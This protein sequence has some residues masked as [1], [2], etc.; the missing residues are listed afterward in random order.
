M[1]TDES[2]NIAMQILKRKFPETKGLD[3]TALGK[4]HQLS[5]VRNKFVQVLH[6]G[7]CHWVCV[8]N[9]IGNKKCD[10]S[11][12]HFYDSLN[13]TGAIKKFIEIQICSFLFCQEDKLTVVI[14]PIQQQGEINC[15]LFA[16]AFGTS[17]L[18]WR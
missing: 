9:F 12:V 1:L 3:D 11:A 7:G 17:L 16:L 14:K 5:I 15:G 6:N 4:V 13:A 18:F 8:D 10:R 2:I